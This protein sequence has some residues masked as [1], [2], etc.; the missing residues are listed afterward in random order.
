MGLWQRL[1]G[2]A[3][4]PPPRL[5]DLIVRLDELEA[6]VTGLRERVKKLTG[7]VTGSM[8]RQEAAQEPAG[9]TNPPEDVSQ[10]PLP[11]MP[12]TDH[13]ARRFRAAG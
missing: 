13:L 9:D 3:P 10:Y 7:L 2:P 5:R 4:A 11:I 12:P 8:R 6:D 1:F